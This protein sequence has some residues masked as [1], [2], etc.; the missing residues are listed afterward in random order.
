MIRYTHIT[1]I[2]IFLVL[3]AGTVAYAQETGGE[4]ERTGLGLIEEVI[5]E[6][7]S[8]TSSGA[9]LSSG[10]S[11][12]GV[13]GC[14]GA[15]YAPVGAQGPRGSHVPTFDGATFDQQKLL[16]YKECVLDGITNSMRETLISFIIKSVVRW[17]N[18]GFDGNPAYVTNLPLHLL[19]RI[20][21]PVAEQFI[22]GGATQTI[23]AE[24]RRDVRTRLAR[25]Y[26]Q[27]T[28]NSEEDLRC[29]LSDKELSAFAAG[30]FKG[31]G[32]W[33]GLFKFSSRSGCNPLLSYYT[34][35]NQL[36]Q[37]IQSEVDREQ[38]QLAWGNG[39]RSVENT[40]DV[41]LGGNQVARVKRIVT[42]GFLIAEHLRQTIGTGLRQSE[43]A[44]EI[45]EVISAL[46]SNIGT[47]V[48]TDLEGLAGLSASFNGRAPYIDR[49][50]EDSA[51]RTRGNMT[52]AAASLIANTTRVETEYAQA[53]QGSADVLGIAS[54]QLVAWENT[55]WSGILE[56]AKEDLKEQVRS[57]VC[58]Q[59]V[60][61]SGSGS[62]SSCSVSV[63][64]TEEQATDA[65]GIKVVNKNSIIVIGRASQNDSSVSVTAGT[66]TNAIGPISPQV[67]TDG[68]WETQPMDLSGLPDGEISVRATETLSSGG[69]SLAQIV[70]T[71]G[72]ETTVTGIELTPPAVQPAVTVTAS[73]SGVS[74][75]A[76]FLPST[77]RSREIR[78]ESIEPILDILKENI[79]RS[80]KAL[81]VLDQIEQALAT[82]AS[83]SAQRFILER[84]D[85]LVS[86]RVLHTEAQLRQA[87]EQAEE[88]DAAM[89]QLLEE[90]RESWEGSWCNPDNWEQH[91]E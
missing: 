87:R 43:N 12:D 20:S 33:A 70:T 58:S 68:T 46:M 7:N 62:S 9:S 86:A 22:T 17:T 72:K 75:S 41:P 73:A 27:E 19:E 54:Q 4:Q 77:L 83:A 91:K 11:R 2:S 79:V 39:F 57:Q 13:Y 30:D 35:K 89:Q 63:S 45:D 29:D 69:G 71:V 38:T 48:L 44:D 24:F 82:T 23:P 37:K 53:R 1:A 78:S 32:G 34:A 90:T 18:Q 40:R 47:E 74:K 64:V 5:N 28:R 81:E 59:Q 25:D 14:T 61:A 15:N 60:G 21:D 76:T 42:P 55:C 85:R 36:Q 16:S 88:I 66:G 31:S 26:A 49:L 10:F 6:L 3:F 8:A 52:G 80:G 50:A 65:I 84:L 56:Q 51:R 67:L